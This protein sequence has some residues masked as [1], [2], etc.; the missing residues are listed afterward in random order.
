MSTMA[1]QIPNLMI[2]YSTVYSCTDQRKHQSYASL[3][4]E[5]PAQSASNEENI[6]IWLHHHGFT[7]S[8]MHDLTALNGGYLR[9]LILAWCI[10]LSHSIDG[11][12]KDYSNSTANALELQQSCAKPLTCNNF[13]HWY[14][15][16]IFENIAVIGI[17]IIS[18]MNA[19][20]WMPQD[21]TLPLP[22]PMLN[23]YYESK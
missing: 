12:M 5:F 9:S 1:S 6:S 4:G 10:S 20:L 11:L 17:L 14:I 13:G 18:Y 19:L 8:G 16:V 22:E 2:V 3:T 15:C 7:G 21:P 23:Q